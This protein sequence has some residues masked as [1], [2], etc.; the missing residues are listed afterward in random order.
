M[1]VFS[2]SALICAGIL[3]AT[4]TFANPAPIKQAIQPYFP[5][6]NTNI[7]K[8]MPNLPGVQY[9]EMT[10]NP[11]KKGFYVTRVKFPA[12]Y[13][14]SPHYHPNNEYD[15]VISGTYYYGTDKKMDQEKS[16]ALPAG[17]YVYVPANSTHYGWTKEETIVQVSGIGPWSAT[18]L[19]K[20]KNKAT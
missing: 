2:K 17:T 6:A 11:N 19:N 9:M 14:V 3:F 4:F 13:T 10:G 20:A 16:T 18:Y 12:N 7:W 5:D 15:T 1:R 8:D